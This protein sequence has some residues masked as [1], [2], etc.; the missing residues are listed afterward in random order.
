M[1]TLIHQQ[2]VYPMIDDRLA[3]LDADSNPWAGDYI[4][5]RTANN[6]GWDSMLEGKIGAKDVSP[7]ASAARAENLEGLPPAF[8][9]AGA[10]DL[11]MEEDVD[12]AKRLA[13]AGV[14]VE[15]HVYP[16]APHGF[17]MIGGTWLWDVHH[18]DQLDAL[19]RAFAKA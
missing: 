13:R 6:F 12:Y 16:G 3:A 2:L 15:L 10:L 14:P 7:Y 8:V 9:T 18:R 17:D 11:L 19:R 4:W 5:T 1:Q